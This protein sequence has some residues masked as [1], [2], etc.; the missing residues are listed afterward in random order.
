MSPTLPS[1]PNL[2]WLRKTAKQTLAELR[3]HDPTAKLAA[4]QLKV[5]RDHGSTSW[6]ALKTHCE[7]AR[8]IA[9]AGVREIEESVREQ[10]L[11]DARAGN[12]AA[13]KG[14]LAA[15]PDLINAQAKHPHWGGRPQALHMAIEGKSRAIFDLLVAS[16][17]DV[18]G[19]SADY[20]G[21]TPLMLAISAAQGEMR[22]ELRR[23]GARVGLVEALLLGDDAHVERL[24]RDG[25]QALPD[26]V[27]GDASL[28]SFARTTWAIDRL[29]ELGVPIDKQD[30]FRLTPKET[31]S[32]LGAAGK[33]LV[34]HLEKRGAPVRPRE[35]A[36]LGDLDRV[37]ALVTQDP[38]IARDDQVF[39]AAIES[40]NFALVE[41]LLAQGANPNARTDYGSQCMALHEAAWIGDLAMV[42]LL[43][44]A[45]ADLRG[46]DVEHQNT[47]SG[48]ARVSARITDNADCVAVAEYLEALEARG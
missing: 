13:V 48:Y 30:Q 33:P 14:T 24:L 29:L 23:R 1:R 43:V 34:R 18:N 40:K 39:M 12:L 44:A 17:A 2:D 4:A 38:G 5:A 37:A 22:D 46:L 9:P 8:S 10:L 6:R 27:P 32:A 20:G 42:K 26:R 19:A 3:R 16:G 41:W 11:R 7:S 47:P 45:G 35:F 25:P 31:L 36:R 21:W 28:L 15:R